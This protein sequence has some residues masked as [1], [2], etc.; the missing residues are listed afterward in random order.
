[1]K[2]LIIILF[3]LI[4]AMIGGMIYMAMMDVQVEQTRVQKEIALPSEV[5]GTVQE[6][7]TT[8][9]GAAALPTPMSA[10]GM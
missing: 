8:S 1:M 10:G 4:V 7:G 3:I 5:S 6:E 9:T 2:K